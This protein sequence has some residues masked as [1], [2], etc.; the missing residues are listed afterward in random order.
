ML[1]RRK[2]SIVSP[3]YS[4]PR[5]LPD[6]QVV[7]TTGAV[8]TTTGAVVT[9]TGAVGHGSKSYLDDITH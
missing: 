6:Y 1:N 2:T 7:T 9:T 5:L 3:D 8:V 4:V